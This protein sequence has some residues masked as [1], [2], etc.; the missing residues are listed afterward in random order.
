M[1]WITGFTGISGAA[2]KQRAERAKTLRDMI[3]AR[4]K[5][6]TIKVTKLYEEFK[7]KMVEK[8]EIE[9]YEIKE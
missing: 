8:G 6:M 2:R 5:V 3:K 4:G 7:E 1:T 9:K